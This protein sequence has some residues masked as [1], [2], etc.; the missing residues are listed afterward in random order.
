MSFHSNDSK[1]VPAINFK[2]YLGATGVR[3]IQV[4]QASHVQNN[5]EWTLE[6]TVRHAEQKFATGITTISNG[7]HQ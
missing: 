3:Y 1:D 7:N 2:K 4:G 6:V 5:N